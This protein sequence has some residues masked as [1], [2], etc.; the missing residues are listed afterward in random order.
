[1][2]TDGDRSMDRL[3][4]EMT[5]AGAFGPGCTPVS[6]EPDSRFAGRDQFASTIVYGTVTVLDRATGSRNRHRLVFKFKHPK[7]ELR[8]MFRND[9]QFHNESLFYERL[10]PLLLDRVPTAAAA[11]Q[12]VPSVAP[13]LC[14]YVYGRNACGDETLRD[15]IVLENASPQGYRLSDHRL[16]LDF[17]HLVLALRTLAK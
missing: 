5:D 2:T 9:E 4:A 3:V 1:M 17:D 6:F 15:V 16:F 12:A 14:R 8:A 13:P 11:G 10:M 7:P